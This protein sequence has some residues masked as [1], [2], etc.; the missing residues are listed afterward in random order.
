MIFWNDILKMWWHNLDI[1]DVTLASDDQSMKAHK[2][3]LSACSPKLENFGNRLYQRKKEL[4]EPVAKFDI[5]PKEKE[6]HL[7][8]DP[9]NGRQ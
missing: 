8:K 5:D 7:Q 2:V 4:L 6:K 3:I 9:C 1:T